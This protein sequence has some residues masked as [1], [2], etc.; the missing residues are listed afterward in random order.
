[1]IHKLKGRY[2]PEVY[3]ARK[4]KKEEDE[5]IKG[6]GLFVRRFLRKGDI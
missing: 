1:M 6:G 3:E 2:I 5:H 4:K